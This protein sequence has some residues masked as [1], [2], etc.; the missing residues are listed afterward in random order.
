MRKSKKKSGIFSIDGVSLTLPFILITTCFALWGFAND[1]LG[2]MTAAFSKIFRLS[3]TEATLVPIAFHLGYFVMAFPAAM[4]IQKYSF[5]AGVMVGLGLFAAGLFMFLPAKGIGDFA[6]FLLSYFVLTCGLSFLETS[7]NPFIYCMGSEETGILRLNMAQAFNPIGALA[8]MYVAMNF[9]QAK[10][11]PVSSAVREQM[12]LEQF[13]MI[14]EYDL[15]VLIQPYIFLGA[16]TVLL[17]VLI[18]TN[19]IPSGVDMKSEKSVLGAIRSLAS[20]KNYR[21]GVIAEFFYT[22]AQVTCWTFIIQYGTRIFMAEGMEEKA[23]EM[24]AQKYNIAAMILFA[25]GRFICT[26]LMRYFT[27][28]RLLAVLAILGTAF[29]AGTICFVDRNG[30]YC[31]IAVSGCMSIMFPT[32]YGLSLRRVGDDMKYA[33]AGLVMAILGGSI[34]PPIQ[35]A[36]ID[37]NIGIAGLPSTNVSFLIPFICFCVIAIYGHHA[38][39]WHHIK[40]EI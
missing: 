11:S 8:G 19:K 9:V 31:L 7:C 35:A 29:V 27:P 37:L 28:E 26:W 20:I 10:M 21:H 1:V 3:V 16:L 4:F 23:A 18:R 38:Y 36:I 5:K 22:G 33:G 32:I 39:V 15:G 40:H 6:P 14:K 12:P 17:L 30:L 34:F 2:P 25:S 13:N 24:L